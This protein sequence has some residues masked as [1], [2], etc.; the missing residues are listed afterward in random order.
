MRISALLYKGNNVE[1]PVCNSRF[2]KFLPYGHNIIRENIL[3]P[4]C[5]S[6]ERHRLM[7][8]FLN[9][10]TDFFT[11]RHKVLHVAPEQ[12]F[13]SRFKKLKNLNYVTADLESP[14][15]DVRL[16][17][18]NMP[19]TDGEFDVVICNHVLEHVEDD[20][21]AMSEILRVLKTGGF[22]IM[23]VPMNS[24]LTTRILKSASGFVFEMSSAIS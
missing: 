11:A 7:W 4:R 1:C 12:C 21:K 17:I 15:A 24:G 22:A 23:H 8:L 6:L 18:Q 10:K 13:Y 3:C 16:D 2:R 9:N 5:L 14:I 20:N 19:F